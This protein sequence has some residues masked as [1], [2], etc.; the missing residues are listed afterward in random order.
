MTASSVW[1]AIQSGNLVGSLPLALL[2]DSESY[3]A[4]EVVAAAIAF[5][6][7]GLIIGENTYGKGAVSTALPLL[8]GSLLVLT[9]A[10]WLTPDRQWVEKKGVPPHI[11]LH[12]NPDTQD[13]EALQHAIATLCPN[14]CPEQSETISLFHQQSK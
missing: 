9:T 13:D 7:R 3:S 4:P 6:K 1:T 2:T 10:K 12:D 14:H 5:H 11:K 8:D